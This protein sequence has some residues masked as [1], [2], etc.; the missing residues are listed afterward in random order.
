MT[1]WQVALVALLAASV[2]ADLLLWREQ[3]RIKL[4]H[5]RDQQ[6]QNYLHELET[7]YRTLEDNRRLR[8]EWREG[9]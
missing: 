9:P 4:A 1:A 2:V 6:T 3:R 7:H 8:A 5:L